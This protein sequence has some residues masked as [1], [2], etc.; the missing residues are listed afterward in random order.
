MLPGKSRHAKPEQETFRG[1][2]S[3]HLRGLIVV[4]PML[5]VK[6]NLLMPIMAIE[7][8]IA[9]IKSE[10]S[11]HDSPVVLTGLF[12]MLVSYVESMQK[13]VLTHYL[14]YRPEELPGKKTMEIDKTLLTANEDFYFVEHF[15]SDAVRRMTYPQ[16]AE[17]FY[18][19]LRIAKPD[20]ESIIVEIKQ[21]RNEVIH[22]NLKMDFKHN[23]PKHQHIDPTYLAY[24]LNEYTIYLNSL[25]AEIES[26]YAEC[27][28]LNA[29][30]ELWRYTFATPLC[31]VFEKF[32]HIDA[33][34]DSIV[35]YKTIESEASLSHSETFMLGI[36]R[37]QISGYRVDFINMSSLGD[38][39][40]Y[41]LYIF[42]KLSNDIF[43]YQ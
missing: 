36:W 17:V 11:V 27:T 3:K 10:M 21:R 25:K 26:R 37:S 38:H 35:G 1:H 24:S 2:G 13:S 15:V 19:T 42:L 41:C 32:W 9:E 18:K 34:S 20:N 29:L 4:K 43:M 23:R 22:K 39:M 40:Q 6:D 31:A 28:R 16:F 33:D 5:V 14:K 8:R 30:R 7:G 12:L